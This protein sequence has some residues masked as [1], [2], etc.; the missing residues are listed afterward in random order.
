MY[1]EYIKATVAE[2]VDAGDLIFYVCH[3]LHK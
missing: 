2:L 1:L 3:F